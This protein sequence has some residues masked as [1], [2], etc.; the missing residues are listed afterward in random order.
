M[1]FKRRSVACIGAIV[2]IAG[3]SLMAGTSPAVAATVTSSISISAP[4]NA[5]PGDAFSISG[6]VSPGNATNT[7]QVVLK[8]RLADGTWQDP[9]KEVTTS[10][11]NYS[12]TAQIPA[13]DP[14]ACFATYV[15][16][17]TIPN[18]NT[19]SYASSSLSCVSDYTPVTSSITA[20]ASTTTP[21]P[22]QTVTIAGTA[23]PANASNPRQVVLKM[24]T[25]GVG[26]GWQDVVQEVTTNASGGYSFNVQVP[27][28][29]N[30]R[31]YITY[32]RQKRSTG[33]PV[34]SYAAIAGGPVCLD[35]NN[36]GDTVSAITTVSP[37]IVE[38]TNQADP[39]DS[40]LAAQI[41]RFTY[42]VGSGSRRIYL[43]SRPAGSGAGWTVSESYGLRSGS[44]TLWAHAL[45]GSQEYMVEIEETTGASVYGPVSTVSS[46]AP[47]FDD[48]FSGTQLS[49]AWSLECSH[50]SGDA[51]TLAGTCNH[52]Q[53]HEFNSLSAISMNNTGTA[54]FHV[55]YDQNRGGA[56]CRSTLELHQPCPV[57]TAHI[58]TGAIIDPPQVDDKA[59]WMAARVK[60]S[61]RQGA[62]A[63]FWT[64]GGLE[65]HQTGENDIVEFSGFNKSV[66]NT[67]GLGE[68]PAMHWFYQDTNDDGS[69]APTP[70]E[71]NY[72]GNAATEA[73]NYVAGDDS[74]DDSYHIFASRWTTDGYTY[75][76]DGVQIDGSIAST[77]SPNPVDLRLSL[78][79]SEGENGDN[80]TFPYDASPNQHTFK[81][82]WVKAW[83]M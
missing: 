47:I 19:W 52:G 73:G 34:W 77:K 29:D 72:L 11:G 25:P 58:G 1:G 64:Q 51:A 26:D 39:E 2:M 20:A 49:S 68:G 6:S 75:W 36:A 13:G 63:A 38:T 59:V 40:S 71:T 62:H 28:G 53:P 14:S 30:H 4:P 10:S 66:G 17:R 81:V 33:G 78:L 3:G 70:P 22:G 15:R 45:W 16:Q 9:W 79:V 74:W 23:S 65:P 37:K 41:G 67:T 18:G 48:E 31:C 12:F 50:G 82:D 27:Q 8:R 35:Q 80:T 46:P 55:L 42:A 32:V 76:I 56:T 21:L 7:R 83:R 5:V 54:D 60:L 57:L 61:S 24:Q 44:G 43:L 69:I